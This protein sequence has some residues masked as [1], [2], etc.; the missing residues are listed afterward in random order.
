MSNLTLIWTTLVQ[1]HAYKDHKECILNQAPTRHKLSC[2]DK[3]IA[4]Q[5]TKN[6]YFMMPHMKDNLR[7]LFPAWL[8]KEL[9]C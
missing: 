6:Q 2:L 7:I 8:A 5:P 4:V 1:L 3:N 9:Y